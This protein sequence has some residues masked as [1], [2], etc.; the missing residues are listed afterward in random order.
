MNGATVHVH[1]RTGTTTS[2]ITIEVP[3]AREAPVT[4]QMLR[5]PV[6]VMPDADAIRLLD[7]LR[8]RY[9]ETEVKT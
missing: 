6:E 3:D 7:A 1:A 9:G 8:D 5:C 4:V 2:C